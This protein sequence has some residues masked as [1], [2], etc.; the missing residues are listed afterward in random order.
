MAS[1]RILAVNSWGGGPEA[2]LQAPEVAGEPG[3][4]GRGHA[5]ACPVANAIIGLVA[6]AEDVDL[7]AVVAADDAAVDAVVNMDTRVVG[8][9]YAHREGLWQ[10]GGR[11][12]G[13]G[14]VVVA[15]CH[16]AEDALVV[17]GQDGVIECCDVSISEGYV[18]D[19]FVLRA[20][21]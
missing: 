17:G 20:L 21:G 14:L 3:D 7:G 2:A 16:D 15:G 1:S 4:E 19:G 5:G 13:H 8:L 11:N 6:S 10:P 18:Q 12:V 9:C